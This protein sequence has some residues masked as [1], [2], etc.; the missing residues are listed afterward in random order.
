MLPCSN[1]VS[2]KPVE[3][4]AKMFSAKKSL[5]GHISDHTAATAAFTLISLAAAKKNETTEPKTLVLSHLK[6]G[7]HFLL[8]L[9]EMNV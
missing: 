6:K 2:P 1:K 4:Q 8:E 9:G 7:A 3:S 5:Q